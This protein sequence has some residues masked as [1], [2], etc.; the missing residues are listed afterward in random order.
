[1][2]DRIEKVVE[3]NAS[4]ERVW[5]AIS[6]HEQFGSWF[7]VCLDGPFHVGRETTGTITYPGYEHVKWKARV[8]DMD[9]PHRFA[10]EWP[11]ADSDGQVREDWPW[12][13]VEFVLEPQGKGTRLTISE[14]GFDRLP[15][16]VADSNYRQNAR[17]WGM[18]ADNI[19]AHVGG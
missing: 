18:Q 12:T 3:L 11:H 13:L 5:Q 16:D 4:V 6:D 1:M 7:R 9:A 2:S 19:A 8:V 10:Y 14:S 15:P 17:G